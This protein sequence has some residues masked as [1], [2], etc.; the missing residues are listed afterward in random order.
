MS[1][2]SEETP[3]IET[4]G[5]LSINIQ[6]PNIEQSIPKEKRKFKIIEYVI[7][8]EDISKF[9]LKEAIIANGVVGIIAL[10]IY[11]P[12]E[13][14]S[15]THIFNERYYFHVVLSLICFVALPMIYLLIFQLKTKKTKYFFTSTEK[16][17]KPKKIISS[18]IQ[19]IVMHA[20][21][22]YPWVLLTQKYSGKVVPL[23]YYLSSANDWALQL[24]FFALNV[25]MFEFYSKA[26]IQTQF[27]EA[28]GA[29]EFFN[30]SLTIQGG[31]WLGFILQNFVWIGGHIQEFFWLKDYL[32]S[33]NAVFFILV[34]GILT[35]LTVLETGNIFGVTVGHVLLNVLLTITYVK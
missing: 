22:F 11:F 8:E 26:F 2:I 15:Y 19:G 14:L 32:G 4:E 27:T 17:L 30:G 23:V 35:G 18:L 25:I 1:N 33:V 21:I 31:K 6:I 24:T 34:S 5:E 10:A 13:F 20:G 3:D 7:R 28:K 16:G 9:S 29:L 12:V